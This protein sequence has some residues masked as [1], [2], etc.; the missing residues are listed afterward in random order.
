MAETP[1]RRNGE[2]LIRDKNLIKE[3]L[4]MSVARMRLRR[5]CWQAILGAVC[6]GLFASVQVWAANATLPAAKGPWRPSQLITPQE[7]MQE[8]AHPRGLKPV[9]VCVGFKFLYDGAHIPGAIYRGPAR[10]PAGMAKLREWARSIPKGTPVV[11]YCGCCPFDR[12]PNVRPAFEVL[13]EAGLTRLR[14]LYIEH[15]FAHDWVAKNY[16]IQKGN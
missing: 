6:V 15:D 10:E 8:L 14:I 16:P 2:Q 4:I 5:I 3:L 7:L 9:I 12:C 13:R 1:D 11:M